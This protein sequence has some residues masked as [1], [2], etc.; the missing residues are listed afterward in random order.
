MKKHTPMSVSLTLNRKREQLTIGLDLGDKWSYYCV[1]QAAVP[2][3]AS[4][5]QMYGGLSSEA[6]FR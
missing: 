4:L 2:A 5:N 3:V 1:S 6:E